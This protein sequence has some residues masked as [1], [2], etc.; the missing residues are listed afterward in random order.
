MQNQE[1]SKANST[2]TCTLI[3]PFTEETFKTFKYE[4]KSDVEKKLEKSQAAFN[5]WSQTTIK[6]R[7]KIV[8]KFGDLMKGQKE[9]IA[10]MMTNEMGKTHVGGLAEVDLCV[11]IVDYCCENA[12]K[13]LSPEELPLDQGKAFN[14]FSPLGV[15]FGIQPWNF[16]FY[17]VI[18]YSVHAILAGNST[19]LRH[20]SNVWA[21][22]EKIEDLYKDAGLPEGVFQHLYAKHEDIEFLYA[23]DEVRLVTF[24]GS[25]STGKK[26]AVNAAKH[27]KKTILELGGNDAYL[28]LEDAD[29][30]LAAEACTRGRMTNNGETC[31][32]AKR[33][34]VVEAVY[35]KFREKFI[36]KMK[37][38]QMGNPHEK[39]TKLG[40]MARK[41]LLE[42]VDDQVRETLDLGAT[43]VMGGNI[44]K[45]K[46]FFFQPTI[47]ENLKPGMPAYDG[48]I[49]G[50]VASLVK[51]K[52]LEEAIEV[53]NNS[54][55][56][57]GGGIFSADV[58]MAKDI[59]SKRLDTG[60]VNING[61]TN[62]RPNLPFGGVKNSG[63]GREH[64][65]FGF[66]AY[67]NVKSV[68]VI[69]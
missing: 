46:G 27:L 34:I 43:C 30:D 16:P 45:R 64:G 58:E 28:V 65:R 55:F 60:M 41:D 51:V 63:Y 24:T 7:V 9:D 62:A 11:A 31:T 49:F 25:P 20:A 52:D 54:Q 23:S 21:S 50:P 37:E 56:G 18:R 69:E 39:T 8:K 44:E 35:D 40:P 61:Y 66:L 48:E 36:E 42:K 68:R 4:S 47:L 67:V 38:F 6:E 17:Q 57:L 33:F 53:S 12:E 1:T 5:K 15:V 2:D 3:N 26:V 13:F 22:A 14:H 29:L 32:A 59:A 10:T 19:L